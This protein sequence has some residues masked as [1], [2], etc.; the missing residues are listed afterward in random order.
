M[1]GLDQTLD[2]PMIVRNSGHAAVGFD[3]KQKRTAVSIGHARENADDFACELIISF[4]LGSSPPILVGAQEFEKLPALL[5]EKD[6][7]FFS[8]HGCGSLKSE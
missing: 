1:R 2:F 7:D 5:L 3:T 8:M 6:S 4:L